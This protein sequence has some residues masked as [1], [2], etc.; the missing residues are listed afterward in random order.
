MGNVNTGS[1]KTTSNSKA[2][3]GA[4]DSIAKQV[5]SMVGGTTY[6][7][8]SAATTGG[9]AASLNAANDPA[10]SSGI[11]SAIDRYS[12]IAG[13]Q[14]GMNDPGY[15]ALR[16]KLQNDV[17][18]GVNSSF[19][20]SGLF[21]ADSNQKS[22]ASGLG[23]ALGGLDYQQYRYGNDQASQA[24]TMLPQLFSAQQL[25]SSIQQAVG[26]AQDAS[27]QGKQ[28]GGLDWLTQLTQGL[29]GA[30]GAAGQ[31]ST[32]QMPLWTVLLGTA[33]TAAGSAAKGG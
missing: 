20:N 17:T 33:A 32:E 30:S 11:K 15:T 27:A 23:D 28:T 29:N 18:A 19:N 2:V 26:A 31:T 22:L 16:S 7:A 4:A 5:Q 24:A 10:Y 8:P 25:P 9:W 21:G 3:T 13:G 14:S 6:V 1:S 12:G